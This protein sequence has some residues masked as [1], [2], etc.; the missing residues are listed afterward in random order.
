MADTWRKIR[1]SEYAGAEE[2]LRAGE[3]YCVAACA[4]FLHK[5]SH[6]HLWYTPDPAGIPAAM[7][8]QSR[9]SLFPILRGIAGIPLP[10]FLNRL[11]GKVSI[12]AVQG[13]RED[14][15]I[16]EEI[17]RGLGYTA[18]DKI[19]YDLMALDGPP[20][21]PVPGPPGLIVRP[22]APG[23]REALFPLQAA[24]EQE[25]VLPRGVLFNPVSCRLS[26]DHIINREQILIACLE[27][28]IVGKI[29]TN[30]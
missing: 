25:E 13:L 10:R 29:N 16:L 1:K 27:G 15:A 24:Y 28:R 2:F 30:A 19:D 3:A 12:H 9:R 23:V 5:G 7:I 14:A 20:E 21:P 8:L 4:R 22:P 17:L 11:F 6:D 26:L 18:A